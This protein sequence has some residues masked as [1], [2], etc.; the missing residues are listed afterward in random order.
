MIRPLARRARKAGGSTPLPSLSWLSFLSPLPLA[1]AATS[2]AVSFSSVSSSTSSFR[3]SSLRA[4]RALVESSVSGSL[5]L[6]PSSA[7]VGGRGVARSL[8]PATGLFSAHLPASPLPSCLHASPVIPPLVARNAAGQQPGGSRRLAFPVAGSAFCVTASPSGWGG[9]DDAPHTAARLLPSRNFSS[10]LPN[11]KRSIRDPLWRRAGWWRWRQREV[12]ALNRGRAFRRHLFPRFVTDTISFEDVAEA[13]AKAFRATVAETGRYPGQRVN[14]FVPQVEGAR[15]DPFS[16]LPSRQKRLKLRR[17]AVREA[18]EAEREREGID[19]VWRKKGGGR[20]WEEKKMN[21]PLG[22]KKLLLYCNIIKGLQI[23]DAIDW[24]SSLCLHRVNYL[25]NLLNATRKKIHEQGGDISRVYVDS[26]MLNIQGKIKR[27]QF[28]LRSVNLIKTW[29]FAVILRFREYPMDEYFHKLFILKHT[30]RSLTTD[31]RLAL[32]TQR[33]NPQA[34]RDW[35]PFLDSKTRFWHRKRLK[36][37]DRTRQ[38]DYCLAR[39]VF[40]SKYEANCRRRRV[41]VLQA[42][43]ASDAVIEQENL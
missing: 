26:Y 28:R 16:A 32:S 23:T 5:G 18:E 11:T 4:R 7:C 38:F 43:G 31:M 30:P 13:E 39:R 33:V 40:K 42:R 1:P 37:L 29:K 41:Q 22:K 12:S 20:V 36:W 3:C 19:F 14:F 6:S 2:A 35:F 25:L 24:L 17:R 8:A 9:A 34:V 10:G 27:P 21:I 15:L